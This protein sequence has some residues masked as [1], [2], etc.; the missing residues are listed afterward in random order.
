MKNSAILI[1]LTAGLI[2]VLFSHSE[3]QQTGTPIYGSTNPSEFTEYS[4]LHKGAGKVRGGGLFSSGVFKTNFSGVSRAHI[5]P[6]ASI[7]EHLHRNVEEVFI[8]LNAPAQFTVN[9]KTSEL[10]AM[11]MVVCNLN[12]SHG[13]YNHNTDTDL[14]WL[15]FAVTKDKG[16]A[17]SINFGEDLA[18][19][20]VE[21]PA[22]FKY[23]TMDRSLLH[24]ISGSH[25]GKGDVLFRRMWDK[26]DFMT[27]WEFID[28][29]VIPPGTSIGYHRHN[30]TEEIYYVVKGSGRMTVNDHTWNVT[31]GDAIPCSLG[32]SHGLF[33]NGAEDIELISCACSIKKGV[34]DTKNLG[35]D[36]TN[37]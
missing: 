23:T 36:L 2:V 10:P 4:S 25:E 19:K 26:D 6:G 35:D 18:N 5:P 14:E 17:G 37:R 24:P 29:Y 27:N 21:S 34:I 13:I 15:F 22:P 16:N 33:N 30:K 20:K 1:L 31:A 11:S 3:A 12:N 8:I 9:G 32:D 7:G 28:H